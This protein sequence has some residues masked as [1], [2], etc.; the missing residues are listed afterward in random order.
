MFSL[1]VMLLSRLFGTELTKVNFIRNANITFWIAK[2]YIFWPIYSNNIFEKL[3]V[4]FIYITNSF[5]GELSSLPNDYTGKKLFANP[6]RIA[7]QL[8]CVHKTMYNAQQIDGKFY[9]YIYVCVSV[10]RFGFSRKL[11]PT[12]FSFSSS[13]FRVLW[14]N[15]CFAKVMRHEIATIYL[16]TQRL[17]VCVVRYTLL[18]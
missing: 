13:V 10:D 2:R 3:M 6:T 12:K 14:F 5:A 1:Y 18:H 16:K 11:L 4:C 17:C 9:L 7:L 15:V 8:L